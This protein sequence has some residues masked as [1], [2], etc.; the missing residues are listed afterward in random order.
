M[1]MKKSE[2]ILC[3]TDRRKTF[4]AESLKK[5]QCAEIKQLLWGR[6]FQRLDH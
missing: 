1:M 5:I 2:R 3:A 6:L 4:A